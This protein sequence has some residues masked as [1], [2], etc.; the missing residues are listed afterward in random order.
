ME[1]LVL[2]AH[3]PSPRARQA[4]QKNTY[5][6][7]QWFARRHEVH[8]LGFATEPEL[9]SFRL[10]DM[11]FFRSFHFL[12]VNGLT[13]WCG[14]LTGPHL[15]LVAAS[16]HSRHFRQELRS[17]LRERRFDVAL[18][19]YT[20]MLQYSVDLNKVPVVVALEPDL[21]FRIWE[22]RSKQL[23]NGVRGILP[24][25]EATRTRRWE[26]D[27]LRRID[28]V[29]SHNPEEGK[30]IQKLLPRVSVLQVD[31]WA[32][33]GRDEKIAPYCERE[34]D[35]L[36]FWGAMDRQENV[37][38]A[39]YTTEK[40]L[41]RI[42]GRRPQA[43]LYVAGN[44]PPGW[45]VDRYRGSHVKVCG[46]VEKPFRVLANKRVALL[47]MRLGAGIKVKVLEC[48]AA[49]L[50]VVTTPA[51][52]EGIP[53]EDGIHYLVGRSEQEL[54]ELTLALL[55]TPRRAEEIGVRARENILEN[56]SFERC[57]QDFEAHIL[58]RLGNSK[59]KCLTVSE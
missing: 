9:Q 43:L 37:D 20:G 17:L 33:L 26:L 35:S 45:L 56:H 41:P 47:P 1:I 53:G 16:R 6:V 30:L 13:R 54:A 36:V 21:S 29:L 10:E 11:G 5:F 4:G 59:P 8:L 19:D 31:V 34:P 25:L 38:A 52:A 40:I 44:R 3:L 58:Q 14:F 24:A 50:P 57:L 7:C 27:R 49:G 23:G 42:W 28:F 2:S 15:P 22:S 55:E 48:M 32:E 46:Y 39:T 18:L 51:G 12:P